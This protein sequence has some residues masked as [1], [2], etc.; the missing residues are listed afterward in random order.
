MTSVM[1]G[2]AMRLYAV[3]RR[4]GWR[5]REELE[6]SLRRSVQVLDEI[7]SDDVRWIRSYVLTEDRG[8]AGTVCIVQAI[9]PEAIRRH[10]LLAQLPVDEIL[11]IAD[12]VLVT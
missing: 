1:S 5:S 4:S 12:T 2:E 9:G 3:L 7:M 6:A 11:A 10:A 8:E